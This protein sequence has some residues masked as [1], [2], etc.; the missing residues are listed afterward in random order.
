MPSLPS[1]DSACFIFSPYASPYAMLSPRLQLFHSLP[2]ISTSSLLPPSSTDLPTL[3]FTLDC[4]RLQLYHPLP[5]V[6]F[7]IPW[8]P[9]SWWFLINWQESTFFS[10]HG[11]GFE[12]T[13]PR[14]IHYTTTYTVE[15]ITFLTAVITSSS[16]AYFGQAA[17]MELFP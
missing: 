9:L 16:Q 11:D 4:S 10:N 13:T 12:L 14:L 2:L 17:K 15:N 6:F 3:S 7:I 1:T 5:H 8:H